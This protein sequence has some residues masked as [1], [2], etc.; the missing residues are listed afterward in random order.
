VLETGVD[1]GACCAPVPLGHN[2]C[3][4]TLGS[5]LVRSA[6]G[7]VVF[8]GAERGGASLATEIVFQVHNV[9]LDLR[10]RGATDDTKFHAALVAVFVLHRVEC[11][12]ESAGAL[13]QLFLV[14]ASVVDEA[15]GTHG[16]RG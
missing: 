5:N 15:V 6:S 10:H 8:A 16:N 13:I 11:V 9:T 14:C 1:G 4:L 3:G 7:L 2:L 12:R